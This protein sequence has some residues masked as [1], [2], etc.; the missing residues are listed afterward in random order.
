MKH[1]L[2][3][4]LICGMLAGA[5]SCD[6]EDRTVELPDL[7][8]PNATVE[9]MALFENLD[10]Y[11]NDQILFGHQDDLAYGVHWLNEEGRSDVMEVTGSYPAMYGWELG[12]LEYGNEEN[13]DGVNFENMKGWIIEGYERGGVIAISWHMNNPVTG[14]DAWDTGGTPVPTVLP[15]GENHEMFNEWLDK[16]ADFVEELRIERNGEEEKAPL[17]FRPYHEHNG[18]WFWWGADHSSPDE[19]KELWQYTVEY[20]RDEKGINH[21]LYAYSPDRFQDS[22]EYL[23]R[24]PGDEYVDI[25]GYDNYHIDDQVNHEEFQ[26]QMGI[27]VELA[28]DRNK[29]PAL[30]ETGDEALET[31][32]WFT[33][34]L[35]PAI[36][37]DELTRRIAYVHVWR[38]ANEETDRV[39][40]FFTPYPGHS[41]EDD[42]IR[43]Y[44]KPEIWFEDDLPDMY[45]PLK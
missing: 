37:E 10:H 16:F 2:L 7:V 36:T 1:I 8:D 27:V 44:E 17:I 19:Y 24:Y 21:M 28:E 45:S 4:I 30:T 22:E 33:E 15:G 18:S 25:L 43:F 3:S 6:V 42:F 41:A 14:G 20:L 13:L 29:I 11:R 12:D 40:H 38:N 34:H 35:Y 26:R 9:T 32:N 39:D 5:V 31:E 23:E